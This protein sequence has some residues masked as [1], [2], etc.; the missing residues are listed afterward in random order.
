[1]LLFIHL[2]SGKKGFRGFRVIYFK[3]E[4][5]KKGGVGIKILNYLSH[6][7]VFKNKIKKKEE[8]ILAIE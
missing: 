3:M 8:N 6:F 5:E 1:M 7:S 4:N 2:H